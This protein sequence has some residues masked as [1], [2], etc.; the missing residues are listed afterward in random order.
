MKGMIVVDMDTYFDIIF[1]KAGGFGAVEMCVFYGIFFYIL[2]SCTG[3]IFRTAG[4]YMPPS[5]DFLTRAIT[6][7][8]LVFLVT[9]VPIFIVSMVLGGIFGKGKAAVLASAVICCLGVFFVNQISKKRN[10]DP[11][12]FFGNDDDGND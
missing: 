10:V 12:V 5:S 2:F 9:N 6:L 4:K 7:L 8:L 3:I 11:S 1:G